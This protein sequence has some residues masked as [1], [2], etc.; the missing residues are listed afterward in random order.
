MG[1]RLPLRL[2]LL[3]LA[4]D[5]GEGGAQAEHPHQPAHR[6]GTNATYATSQDSRIVWKI[7]S[8]VV[9]KDGDLTRG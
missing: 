7:D 8:W 2:L 5:G 9:L 6:S 3:V 4:A 1:P